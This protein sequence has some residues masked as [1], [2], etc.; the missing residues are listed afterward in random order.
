[1]APVQIPLQISP[2][3][4]QCMIHT[5]VPTHPHPAHYRG[6]FRAYIQVATILRD[7]MLLK[8]KTWIAAARS[9][10]VT[11]PSSS[12]T[13]DAFTVS[14]NTHAA[15]SRSTPD[16]LSGIWS[17]CF[18]NTLYERSSKSTH[19]IV[20]EHGLSYTKPYCHRLLNG[21]FL[22]WN[23]RQQKWNLSPARE[24]DILLDST[25]VGR[26]KR[27]WNFLSWTGTLDL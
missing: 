22:E 9:L 24:L 25:Q 1:M 4:H 26:L 16:D 17:L 23:G 11:R 20:T 27:N 7:T 13:C 14:P 6:R 21:N 2:I 19:S 10:Y 12:I 18:N 8:L 3:H 15:S 5:W